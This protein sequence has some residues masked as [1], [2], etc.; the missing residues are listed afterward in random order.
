MYPPRKAIAFLRWF[1]RE[2]CIEEIEG[3]LT[4][5][6][7]KHHAVSPRFAK[8]KFVWNVMRYFRP[9]FIKSFRHSPHVNSYGM[10]KSYLKIGW[11]NFIGNKGYSLINV[12]G[13]A[14]GISVVILIGLWIYDE[15][16]Y[17]KNFPN[18]NRIARVVQNQTIN[19]EIQTW[20]SQAMQLGPELQTAYGNNFEHVI[21]ASFPEDIKLSVGTKSLVKTGSYMEPGVTDMLT[22]NI[23][24]GAHNGLVSLNSILL[25]QSTAKAL[26]GYDDPI[27]K[28]IR[29][30]NNLDVKVTGVYEDFPRNSSFSNLEVIMPWQLLVK[31]AE[32]EKRVSWGN[33]W[34]QCFVQIAEKADMKSVSLAIKD[35]KLKRV[36][37]QDNNNARFRPELFL[38][39]MSRWR[40]HS[41][42]ENG[43]SVGGGIKN[44]R[45]LGAIGGVVLLLACINFMNLS[46]ARS[47]KRAKEVGIRK[48]VGSAR[49]HLISQFFTESLI[50]ALISF[51]LSILIVLIALPWF[52]GVSGK[53][54][55]I[56]W[57]TPA[58]WLAS[59]GFVVV[60][61]LVAGSYPALFLSSFQ[62]IKVLKGTLS[63]GRFSSIPRKVL[64]VVQFTVSVTLI[65]S[66]IVIFRQIR[67][68]QN[69]PLGYAI[70]GC[71]TVPIKSREMMK[72]YDALRDELTKTGAVEEMAA[73]ESAI[74]DTYVTNSGFDW[75]GKEP[76]NVEEFVTVGV[77]HDFGK[78]IGWQIIEG[79][80]FSSEIA[81]DSVAFIINEAAAKLIGM[82]NPVGEVIK[83]N[84]N[85]EWKIIG[86]VKDMVTQ[87][88]YAY[89]K[90]ML[91]FIKSSKVP[92][93]NFNV[94]EIKLNPSVDAGESMAKIAS[95]FKKYDPDNAFE[96]RFADEEF[97]KKFNE[98]KRI[99][100]LAFVFTV[101]AIFISCLGLFGLA[102]FVAE[103]RTKEIGI[104]KV[105]G[106]SVVELWKMLSADFIILV[107]I[108][109]VAAIPIAYYL[110]ERW[111]RGYE[112]RTEISW[113][114]FVVTSA[115]AVLIT[116]M[117]VS[118]QAI[119]AA[120]MNP[121]KSLRSE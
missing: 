24:R 61:G 103:Q 11:R 20:F 76:D 57:T 30:N 84:N 120:R 27:D 52:N 26:F 102:S 93:I 28:L 94:I 107:V 49:S 80:D 65:I 79:K 108:A 23:T 71:I 114:I 100:N 78:V 118:F 17:D 6:F 89:I 88:P 66:T 95:V 40:L 121:T 16:S 7:R 44:V 98:E 77:T 104:R 33:S 91:F 101:I 67:F 86:V 31:S 115:S 105:I 97:G 25:S 21:T 3:D 116:L 29:V 99:G 96:Y 38:H 9:E 53:R 35:A 60:T 59:T 109:S 37:A 22:L 62:P 75:T 46:T 106:A 111:L 110:M 50:V 85:G 92:F 32:L 68:A 83:W 15:V 82:K 113:W 51:V 43:V 8:W 87:S 19:G 74:T 72:H 1:C 63:V 112:Y 42:F 56:L 36:L 69:R 45:M 14:T 48:S 58:F 81:S 13:L 34:F 4:E 18:Y 70:N 2:E 73:S 119:K 64:V 90:P 41:E 55:G 12:G 54:L 47:E 5:V 10:Y 39:P 117:T